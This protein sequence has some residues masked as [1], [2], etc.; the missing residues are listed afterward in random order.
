MIDTQ[1]AG[2][3]LKSSR[4]CLHECQEERSGEGG[5]AAGIDQYL[6]RLAPGAQNINF[7]D[8]FPL[9]AISVHNYPTFKAKLYLCWSLPL[10]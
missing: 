10:R 6:Y 4:R 2:G 9:A 1:C 7:S 8:F 5:G 3:D